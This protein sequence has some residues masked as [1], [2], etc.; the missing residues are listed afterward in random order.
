[1]TRVNG[2]GPQNALNP[3]NLKIRQV[4]ENTDIGVYVW[5]LPDGSY[6]SD[7]DG[8]FLSISS[9]EFD[10]E[11]M[12]KLKEAAQYWGKPEGKVKFLAGAGKVTDEE[13]EED[14]E[15]MQSG[16]TPYGDTGAWKD[17]ADARRRGI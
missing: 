13:Y 12:K 14:M 11:K 17:E 15:R 4:R 7:G 10:I 9:R 6:F 2:M 5:E 16:L 3:K 8:N 1:M